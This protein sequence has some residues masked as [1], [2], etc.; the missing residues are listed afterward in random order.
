[1]IGPKHVDAGF[2]Q[3]IKDLSLKGGA[4]YLTSY[5]TREEFRFRPKYQQPAHE[6]P[7]TGMFFPSDDRELYF[8]NVR[9]VLGA[10]RNLTLPPE[11][12][13]WGI[14]ASSLVP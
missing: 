11:K 6:K 4:L 7:F 9:D 1:M 12:G 10:R 8:E 13:M 5:L 2:M 3:R 14:V